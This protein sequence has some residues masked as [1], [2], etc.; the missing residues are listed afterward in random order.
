VTVLKD[1][2]IVNTIDTLSIVHHIRRPGNPYCL[3]M[4]NYQRGSC[5]KA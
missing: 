3:I 5:R 4:K 1:K 2:K